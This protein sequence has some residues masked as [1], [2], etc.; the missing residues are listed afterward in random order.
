MRTD[1]YIGL[2]ERAQELVRGTPVFLFSEEVTR[3]Y[4][5]GRR[6]ILPP[7]EVQGSSVKVEDNGVIEGAWTDVVSTLHKHTL[8]DGRVLREEVQANPWS[9]GPCYFVALKDEAGNWVPESLWTDEE[10]EANT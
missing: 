2:N 8:P 5:D 7:R 3:V 9:S 10:I 4:P 1:Q 6:E